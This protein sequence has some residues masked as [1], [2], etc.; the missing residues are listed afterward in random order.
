MGSFY[1]GDHKSAASETV[2]VTRFF[3]QTPSQ[4]DSYIKI[5]FKVIFCKK[6]F[7]LF[8]CGHTVLS[9]FICVVSIVGSCYSPVVGNKVPKGSCIE[10]KKK[11]L[12]IQQT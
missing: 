11:S 6:L 10:K 9:L 7:V 2:F 8:I 4:E 5:S 3:I 12:L 1:N